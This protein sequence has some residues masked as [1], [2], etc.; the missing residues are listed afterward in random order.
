MVCFLP[1]QTQALLGPL[2]WTQNNHH[3]CWSQHAPPWYFTLRYTHL[4]RRGTCGPCKKRTQEAGPQYL[5][6]SVGWK[7]GITWSLGVGT[8]IQLKI[9]NCKCIEIKIWMYI[10]YMFTQCIYIYILLRY[11]YLYV[12]SMLFLTQALPRQVHWPKSPKKMVFSLDDTAPKNNPFHLLLL[13][14]VT[15]QFGRGR[16][17]KSHRHRKRTVHLLWGFPRPKSPGIKKNQRIHW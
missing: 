2:S 15:C 11:L 5:P 4:Y 13:T 9:C 7:Y 12:V 14:V 3:L 16:G 10:F 6:R 8:H 17:G 1:Q